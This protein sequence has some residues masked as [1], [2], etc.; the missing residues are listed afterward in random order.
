MSYGDAAPAISRDGRTL[1]FI[2]LASISVGDVYVQ[3]FNEGT[4]P[5]EAGRRL[6]HVGWLM[7]DL[8]WERAGR[9][10]LLAADSA[11]TRRLWRLP[12]DRAEEPRLVASLNVV[13]DHVAI[14]Q[15]GDRLVYANLSRNIQLWRQDIPQRGQAQQPP[16]RVLAS[17]SSDANPRVSPDGRKIAFSSDATGSFEIWVA[18]CDGSHERQLTSLGS[19]SGSPRWSP[20][21]SQIVFDSRAHGNADVYVVSAGGGNVR[22][23]TREPSNDYVPSWSRD[24]RWIYFVSNR[25][26]LD[27]LW[28]MPADGGPATQVTHGGAADGIESADSRYVY[29][30]RSFDVTSVWRVPAGGGEEEKVIDD[31]LFPL[32]FDVSSDGVYYIRAAEPR[33]LMLYS[34]ERRRAEKIANIEK[35]FENGLGMSPDGRWFVYSTG[36]RAAGNLMMVENFR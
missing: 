9:N 8:F 36:Q 28:R 32:N 30:A 27:Q 4:G 19:Y 18:D 12:V 21:S 5:R 31:L 1:A 16:V 15:Q 7:R 33:A 25:S 14:S 23:L 11:Q 26:G 34:F 2:R 22:Q 3:P 35:D 24:G 10:L 29:F 6:T 17:A 13:G 20:D